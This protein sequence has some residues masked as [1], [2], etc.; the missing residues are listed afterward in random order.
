MLACGPMANEV[1]RWPE[2][3][4]G[5]ERGDPGTPDLLPDP[6]PRAIRV[7]IISVDDHL[8]EPPDLFE[9]RVPAG[10]PDG[11][12][13]S[14]RTPTA[15]SPGSTRT[16]GI[17]TSG[18][19]PSSGGRGRRGAWTRP[20]SRTCG[21]GCFDIRA[22]VADMDL[23]GVWASL[24]F[25]SLVAGFC[26]SVFIR[27]DDPEL[28]LACLRA[29][30]QWHHEVW[31][32]TYPDRIIP[33]QLPWLADV[34]VA[35]AEVRANAELGFKAV[36]FPEFP[37][38][39]GLPSIF[40]GHWDPFFAACE[41]TGTVVCLHTGSSAW[42]PLPSPSPPVRAAAHPLPGQRPASPRP[43]GCGRGSP[44]LP[45]A[46]S[47][48]LRG[49]HRLGAHAGRPGR[50]RPGPLGLGRGSHLVAVRPPPERGAEA[51]LLVLHHRR[52]LAGRPAPRH[53]GRPHHGGERLSPRRLDL[54]RHPVG[55]CRRPWAGWTR[56]SSG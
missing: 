22:R 29:W 39:L 52:P 28:G 48:P 40:T 34:E 20:G 30:N 12:P 50:L 13:A 18:S 51:Q 27:S 33:L 56:G 42:A 10:W 47:G 25:P 5:R 4:G 54:A 36:S 23:N 3:R 1:A 53:R 14:S 41:E 7:P 45:R 38:Q 6:E 24:C 21:P 9:G 46:G 16:A 8:I 17:R 43:S 19:T 32:G 31:A 37:A 2:R 11:H 55:A 49:R 44:A 26:G 15:P 35:A